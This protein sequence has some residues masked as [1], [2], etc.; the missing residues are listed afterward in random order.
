MHVVDG[1]ADVHFALWPAA[2]GS[3]VVATISA[4]AAVW[5]LR[6]PAAAA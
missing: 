2:V 4:A 3:L 5:I 1:L 6:Q